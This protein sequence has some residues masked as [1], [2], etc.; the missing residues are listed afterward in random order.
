MSFWNFNSIYCPFNKEF[1]IILIS[2]WS[3]IHSSLFRNLKPLSEQ[4]DLN[5]SIRLLQSLFCVI[6]LNFSSND[7]E[8][9]L[10][11]TGTYLNLIFE[12]QIWR[13]A[14]SNFLWKIPKLL[15]SNI[16]LSLNVYFKASRK[17]TSGF[18]SLIIL[19]NSIALQFPISEWMV[20][21][22][23]MLCII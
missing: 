9:S 7:L 20:L 18:I 13:A 5:L 14:I 10:S 3:I 22:S 8:I 23:V 12:E 6:K 19:D 2:S 21:I 1:S 16:W 11:R 17:T 4:K 15:K